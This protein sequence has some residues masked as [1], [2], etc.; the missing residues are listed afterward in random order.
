PP[1]R[2]RRGVVQPVRVLEDEKRRSVEERADE[3]D[4]SLLEPLAPEALLECRRL[5]RV[6]EP[7]PEGGRE[8][9]QPGAKL[10]RGLLDL[11]VQRVR[12][13]DGIP[14]QLEQR[15]QERG[16]REVGCRRLV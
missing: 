1:Q 15:A 5:R 9:R 3:R 10:R 16:E 4:R 13:R 14:R 12:G 2:L 11:S 6:G 7:E 8:E